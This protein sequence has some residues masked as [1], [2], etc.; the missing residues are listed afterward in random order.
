MADIDE[1]NRACES[2]QD[3]ST[4]EFITSDHLTTRS[5]ESIELA[6]II[7]SRQSVI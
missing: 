5:S 1:Q 6:N 7:A 4:S 2:T 3:M